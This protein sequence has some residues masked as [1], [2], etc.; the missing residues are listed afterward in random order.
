MPSSL[1][2][3]VQ[4]ASK[5]SGRRNFSFLNNWVDNVNTVC[6]CRQYNGECCCFIF[7]SFIWVEPTALCFLVTFL[8]RTEVR[9]YKIAPWLRHSFS[10]LLLLH[11][12]APRTSLRGSP[13][14]QDSTMATP[15]VFSFASLAPDCAK[16]I[17]S[18]KSGVTR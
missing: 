9:S 18:G 5:S 1:G 4:A 7:F 12:T 8:L 11:R 14:L 3:P 10:L 13:E 6:L 2:A 16:D 17:P 15:L